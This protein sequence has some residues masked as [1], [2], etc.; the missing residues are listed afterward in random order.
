LSTDGYGARPAT[1]S[2]QTFEQTAK[3]HADRPALC[4]KRKNQ[5]VSSYRSPVNLTAPIIVASMQGVLPSAWKVWTWKEYHA[6]CVA[7]AKALI[8]S[9]VPLFHVV[10][11]I[12]F[13]SPE[14]VIANMGAILAGDIAAGIYTSNTPDACHYVSSHS[15]AEFVVC[16]GNTQ[17]A[18]YAKIEERLPD[19]KGV[20]VWGETPD[21]T[22]VKKFARAKVF[23]WDEWL[24]VGS[25]VSDEALKARQDQIRPGNCSTLIYTSGTTGPP[26]AVMISHDNVTWTVANLLDNYLMASHADRFLSYLPLS[27]IAAQMIDIH[28]PMYLG[29][30][31]WFAQP[32]ALKGTLTASMKEC[33][34]TIFFGVP[35][36]WEKIHEKMAAIGRESTGI[37]KSLGAWAKG[38]GADHCERMQFGNSGGSSCGYGCANSLVLS[39]IK[40]ALGLDQARACFTAA[41]PISVE[42]LRYFASLDIP[43]YE[44]FGQS[45]CT[46]PHTVGCQ[47]QWK[48]GTCGRAMLGTETMVAEG[49]KELC[50]RG[51]HIFMG[52]MR[53][54]DKTAETIDD[55]GYLH[56]GDIGEFD[57][58][59][60]PRVK[61]PSGFMRITGRIK[62]IIITAGGENIPPILIENEMKEMLAL[63]NC[64]VVGDRQKYLA[65]LISLKCEVDPDSGEPTDKLAGDALYIGQQIGSTA[66]TMSEAATDPKW[67]KYIEDGMKTANGKTTSNAQIVQKWAMLPVDFSEKAGLLTPTL[68]LKRN[69]AT[70]TYADLIASIYGDDYKQKV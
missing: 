18:K 10:N 56:S 7:F 12:G 8:A 67:K 29:A 59:N 43:V 60:D 2:I 31:T 17:L 48:M 13:N 52:Y 37:K 40:E 3:T 66:T 44:V 25:G 70:E 41:A 27:H 50:Y 65:M 46:G 34:P 62:D 33:K 4:L 39:K 68:K 45:E 53:M 20:I 15:K 14:W 24:Q 30:S 11:M 69:V 55:E 26:K 49:S 64:M 58:D 22:I 5:E 35:R 38:L 32:D 16:E 57:E 47:L 51:R 21:P 23:T 63:A 1:T 36:V 9:E 61:A 42:T 28:A 19:L 54:P 6:D